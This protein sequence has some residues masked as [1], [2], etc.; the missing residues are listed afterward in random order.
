MSEVPLQVD[1]TCWDFFLVRLQ[2]P[3]ACAGAMRE[4]IHEIAPEYRGKER[5]YGRERMGTAWKGRRQPRQTVARGS[6]LSRRYI[7]RRLTFGFID[8]A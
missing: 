8:S 7:R 2:S 5:T 3:P 6:S 1:N 4:R